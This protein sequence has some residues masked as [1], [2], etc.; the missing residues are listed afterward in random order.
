[1]STSDHRDL[2]SFPTRRSSDLPW[3]E[4]PRGEG[5]QRGD[6]QHILVAV[7]AA[8]ELACF[9]DLAQRAADAIGEVPTRLGQRDAAALA[10]KK[11]RDRQSTR[12]NSRHVEISYAI[13]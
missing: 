9:S 6:R 2:H 5:W 13:F 11:S 7:A 1:K 12:L 10:V 3:H 4:P 8:H